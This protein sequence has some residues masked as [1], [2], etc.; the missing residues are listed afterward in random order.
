MADESWSVGRK[1]GL[2]RSYHG[3]QHS[4]DAL[5]WRQILACGIAKRKPKL[6]ILKA[7]YRCSAM[8]LQ[9][10]IIRGLPVENDVDL[11]FGKSISRAVALTINWPFDKRWCADRRVCA[12]CRQRLHRGILQCRCMKYWKLSLSLCM[13]NCRRTIQRPTNAKRGSKLYGLPF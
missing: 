1:I 9:I 3:C 12:P 13:E 6:R 11:C 8:S 10:A 7:E 5:T 4:A 2:E